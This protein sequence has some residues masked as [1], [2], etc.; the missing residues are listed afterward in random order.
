MLIEVFGTGNGILAILLIAVV[1][2]IIYIPTLIYTINNAINFHYTVTEKN[3]MVSK[4]FRE[5]YFLIVSISLF[6]VSI[7]LEQIMSSVIINIWKNI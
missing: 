7:V 4:L 6:F 3:I 1:P 5:L 2:N